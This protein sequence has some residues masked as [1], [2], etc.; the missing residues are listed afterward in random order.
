MMLGLGVLALVLAIGLNVR[1][2]LNNYGVKDNKLHVEVLAQT[3]NSGSGSGSTGSVSGGTGT[4]TT[5]GG[6]GTGGGSTT[7][8][9]ASLN[10]ETMC[11]NSGGY[12]NMALVCDGGGVNSVQCTISGQLTVA[13]YTVV[14]A[15]ATKGKTYNVTWERWACTSTPGAKNCCISSNQGV[16]ITGLG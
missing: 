3:N 9:G 14:N 8:P 12:W 2:A 5:T 7:D 6:S 11:K 10:D 16:K 15:S 4:G 1:H 13:G